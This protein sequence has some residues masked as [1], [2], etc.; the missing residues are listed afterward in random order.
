MTPQVLETGTAHLELEL[1]LGGYTAAAMGQEEHT[2]VYKSIGML[3]NA[4]TTDPVVEIA[5]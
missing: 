3:I 4:T 1:K 2:K 5:A